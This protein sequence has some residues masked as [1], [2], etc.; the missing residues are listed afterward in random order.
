MLVS[1]LSVSAI[2]ERGANPFQLLGHAVEAGF[3]FTL[4][5]SVNF[6]ENSFCFDCSTIS[7]RA[8]QFMCFSRLH[9]ALRRGVCLCE[10]STRMACLVHGAKPVLKK[11]QWKP[12]ICTRLNSNFGLKFVDLS[13]DL[14]D[15]N[16]N[17]SRIAK[18]AE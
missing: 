4:K 12:K 18:L 8:F 3:F 17:R 15:F 14:D 9:Y 6:D 7:A 10:L 2:K 1:L 11:N 16:G 5:R 13:A